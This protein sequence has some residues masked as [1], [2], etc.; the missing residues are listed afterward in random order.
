MQCPTANKALTL[1]IL[2]DAI[3]QAFDALTRHP[4]RKNNFFR[5]ILRTNTEEI[6]A[7]WTKKPLDSNFDHEQQ[8]IAPWVVIG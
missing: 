3:Y 2:Q 7:I 1:L 6:T 4:N 5:Q 8:P